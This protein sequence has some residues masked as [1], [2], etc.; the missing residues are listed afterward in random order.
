MYFDSSRILDSRCPRTPYK[1]TSETLSLVNIS[2]K[3]LHFGQRKLLLS[4][5]E[6]LT[7]IFD[8]QK[9]DS[10]ESSREQRPVLVVYPGAANGSHLPI[11]FCLF[12]DV[13]FILIDPAPFCKELE[14]IAE[15]EDGPV[16]ELINDYCTDELCLRIS[17]MYGT[18][19]DLYIVSDIR[20]GVPKKMQ[21]NIE[22]TEMILHD[23]AIQRSW[24][25]SLK[26]IAAMLKFHPPYPPSTDLS[27]QKCDL[28]DNTPNE[29]EYFDGIQLLGVWAPKSSSE[30]R[31]VVEGPFSHGH[32]AKTRKYNC[33]THEEQCYH[34]NISNRYAKDCAAERVIMDRYLKCVSNK[35]GNNITALS[36]QISKDLRFP[37]FC[38]LEKDF[39]EDNARWLYLLYSSRRNNII[40]LYEPFKNIMKFD[41]VKS[42][43]KQYGESEKVPE[44]AQVSGKQLSID[45]WKDFCRCDFESAYS[46]PRIQWK[47]YGLLESRCTSYKRE[48]RGSTSSFCNQVKFPRKEY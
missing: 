21:K 33:R 22:H 34:Y 11:L 31:L 7:A 42:L 38:P 20:T 45:F 43:I 47:F 26:A 4:E 39:T 46:L 24:C 9:S 5:I 12:K 13:R 40:H 48:K 6:F 36:N 27:V 3:G 17:R 2:V 10:V 41:T 15:D 16:I 23:N 29:I 25:W 19:Y 30:V 44:N 32:I 8:K 35:Y 18:Q 14:V 1:P 28:D 37:L